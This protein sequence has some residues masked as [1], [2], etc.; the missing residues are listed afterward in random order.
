MELVKDLESICSSCYCLPEC[1]CKDN[2]EE[3]RRKMDLIDKE[4]EREKSSNSSELELSE[5]KKENFDFQ[6]NS[7]E[8]SS[9]SSIDEVNYSER[10]CGSTQNIGPYLDTSDADINKRSYLGPS[11]P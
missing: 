7:W 8:S 6:Y 11:S 10:L 3:L 5:E 2:D 4:I 9:E 1:D